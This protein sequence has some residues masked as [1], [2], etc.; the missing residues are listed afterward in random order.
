MVM[1]ATSGQAEMKRRTNLIGINDND[2]YGR[3]ILY[4]TIGYYYF[5]MNHYLDARLKHD[6]YC[7]KAYI[8]STKALCYDIKIKHVGPVLST[9]MANLVLFRSASWKGPTWHQYS[10]TTCIQFCTLTFH[11]I[12]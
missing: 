10:C 7:S 5:S 3:H 4:R 9:G 2:V 11:C 12:N 6:K 8:M 1:S